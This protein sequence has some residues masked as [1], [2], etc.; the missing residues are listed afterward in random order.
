LALLASLA[1]GAANQNPAPRV[2]ADVPRVDASEQPFV[3]LVTASTPCFSTATGGHAPITGGATSETIRAFVEKDSE[4]AVRQLRLAA[5][6]ALPAAGDGTMA[7]AHLA[8]P[9]GAQL[10]LAM[11]DLARSGRLQSGLVLLYS[12]HGVKLPTAQGDRSHLCLDVNQPLALASVIDWVGTQQRQDVPWLSLILNACESAHVD[13]RAVSLPVGILAASQQP[14]T[15]HG[16]PAVLDAGSCERRLVARAELQATPFMRATVR[17]L[18]EPEHREHDRNGDGIVTLHEL[19]HIFSDAAQQDWTRCDL[20]RP[21][22][23]LQLQSRSDIPVRYHVRASD[24]HAKIRDILAKLDAGSATID[25]DLSR[26]LEAQLYLPQRR[27]LPEM[28]WDFVLADEEQ[29]FSVA[30]SIPTLNTNTSRPVS[31]CWS[32]PSRVA[33]ARHHRLSPDELKTLATYSIFSTF[34]VLERYG[35]GFDISSPR[36]DVMSRTPRTLH[37]STARQSLAAVPLRIEQI[38]ATDY[39][40][41]MQVPPASDCVASSL[42]PVLTRMRFKICAEDEG[43]CFSSP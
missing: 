40:F 38:S 16:L 28:E 39:R 23:T 8:D 42:H 9:T 17:A 33:L 20:N 19:F 21:E 11:K 26:A 5:Y 35:S 10:E 27:V 22:P 37:S 2:A 24:T 3:L 13:L 18:L 43:Q 31:S 32:Y 15:V 4:L 34:Y 25:G 36:E 14:M 7:G 30:S 29:H 1:C 12:G 6:S 41:T